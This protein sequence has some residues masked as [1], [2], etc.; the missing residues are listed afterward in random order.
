MTLAQ[1]VVPVASGEAPTVKLDLVGL[2]HNAAWPVKITIGLLI[3]CSLLVWIIAVLKSLQLGRLRIA[4]AA[5]DRRTRNA[6]SPAELYEL[7]GAVRGRAPGARV[8]GALY[9]RGPGAQIERLRAAA[10]RAILTE[11]QS[12]RALMWLLAFIAAGA[13]FIGLFGTVYGIMDAFRSIGEKGNASLPTVAP[14]IGEALITTAIGLAAAIPAVIFF[15]LLDRM[16]ESFVNELEASAS[17]W[18]AL[19][20]EGRDS[21]IPLVPARSGPPTS[22][23]PRSFAQR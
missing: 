17:E 16:V 6:S 5:F 13:P 19:I 11:G 15:N 12:A 20:A 21:A 18:V 7:T 22:Q 2:F 3:G 10:D 23:P 9:A 14:A 8:I 1:Q 4:E